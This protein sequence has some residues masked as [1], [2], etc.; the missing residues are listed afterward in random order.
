[1]ENQADEIEPQGNVISRRGFLRRMAGV[2]GAVFGGTVL[3]VT[4]QRIAEAPG[5]PTP[6]V[7]IKPNVAEI[8]SA[9]LQTREALPANN[10][11]SLAN[12]HTQWK[13][14][15]TEDKPIEIPNEFDSPENPLSRDEV[16]ALPNDDMMKEELLKQMD[17]A[18]PKKS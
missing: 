16:L 4:G 11:K 10:G 12:D 18:A 13:I 5:L 6:K 2:V 8:S 14:S 1:M 17:Q 9:T 7:E 3:G 15:K